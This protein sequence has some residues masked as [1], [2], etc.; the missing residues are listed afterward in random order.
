MRKLEGD[1]DTPQSRLAIDV[2]LHVS[3]QVKG[4]AKWHSKTSI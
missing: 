3:R 2:L 4:L 1:G